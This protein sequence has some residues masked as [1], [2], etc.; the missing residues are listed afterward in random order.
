MAETKKSFSTTKTKIEA[1]KYEVSRSDDQEFLVEKDKAGA[2][3]AWMAW[4]K[5]DEGEWVGPVAVDKTL[6]AVVDHIEND[7]LL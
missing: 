3:T 2:V 6:S 5:D 1:G 4:T 7:A